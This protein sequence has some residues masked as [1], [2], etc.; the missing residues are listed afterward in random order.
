MQ[1]FFKW[2]VCFSFLFFAPAQLSFAGDLPP[3]QSAKLKLKKKTKKPA[4]DAST[5]NVK[6]QPTKVSTG[7]TGK[8]PKKKNNQMSAKTGFT[9]EGANRDG[10]MVHRREVPL[11]LGTPRES[12]LV[13]LM[14]TVM[15]FLILPLIIVGLVM[16]VSGW[17][18]FVK[19][20]REGWESLVPFLNIFRYVQIARMPVWSVVFCF[21]PMLNIMFPLWMSYALAKSFNKST[22][23]ALGL[24]FLPIIFYPILAFGDSTY[25]NEYDGPSSGV[26]FKRAS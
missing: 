15:S 13:T 21:L 6:E 7:A 9:G 23:F 3:T 17:K 10:D 1:K 25:S 12:D 19:A 14:S 11:D 4:A 2:I 24:I 16:V 22:G 8:K 26:G 20:G 18:I 5:A